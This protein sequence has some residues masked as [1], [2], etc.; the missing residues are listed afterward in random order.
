MRVSRKELGGGGATRMEVDLNI[1]YRLLRA[2][3][4]RKDLIVYTQLSEQYEQETGDWVDPHLG[5]RFPLA[6]IA[7]RCAGLCRPKH[8]PILP[9][10]V[11]NNPEGPSEL[12]GRPGLGFWGLRSAAGVVLTPDRPS[13]DA[14]VAM[15][16][17]VYRQEWPA[18]FDGLPA[19]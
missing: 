12:R 13:E 2:V 17:A 16:G 5:W 11:I 3:A 9:A 6:N 10:I 19:A 1:L 18:E 4:V 15:C 14:W 7:Y 8:Q